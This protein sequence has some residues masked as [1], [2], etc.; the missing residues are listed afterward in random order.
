MAAPIPTRVA[1]AKA[2]GYRDYPCDICGSDDAVEIEVA[3][4][5]TGDQAIHVCRG[6]GFVYVRR[7]RT[8]EAIAKEWSEELFAH[9]YTARV[10]Y[11]KARHVFLAE[12][13]DIEVGLKGKSVCDIGA[14]EG[15]FLKL[16]R[17]QYGAVPFGVEPSRRNCR[18]MDQDGIAN[19]CGTIESYAAAGTAAGSFDVVTL[20]WTLENCESPKL[21][22]DE[23]Y[24]LLKP[25]GHIL[26][27]TSSRIL[28]PFKKPLNYYLGP[29][30]AADTHAF[31]FSARA[32]Q[33]I[34]ARCGFEVVFTNR[35]I[36]HDVLCMVARRTDK[37][38][39]IPAEKDDWH[40]VVDYFNRWDKDT[41]ENFSDGH[42]LL[43]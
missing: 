9:H 23:A 37:S 25:T 17:D 13:L 14:G 36:D 33:A 40:K 15:P 41:R 31:R 3:R 32:Q 4:K 38:R 24:R 19:F 16:V 34:L 30:T 29:T 21:M 35:Y 1:G 10:P 5:Y 8:A 12:T 18:L 39:D 28:V 42:T 27:A 22:L 26:L 20:M 11:M 2:E 43:P 7:R 6:C